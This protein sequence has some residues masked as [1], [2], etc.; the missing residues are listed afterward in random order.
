MDSPRLKLLLVHTVLWSHYKAAVFSSSHK[1]A[2]ARGI[3]FK[4]IQ[5][6]RNELK[7]RDFDSID[8][9]VHNYPYEL[10]FDDYLESIP[11]VRR[12]Q[13]VLRAINTY[14]PDVLVI[15]GYSDPVCWA[16]L[17][18]G[19]WKGI[20][21]ASTMGSTEKDRPRMAHKEWAKSV[22]LRFIDGVYCYGTPQRKYLQKLGVSEHKIITRRQATDNRSIREIFLKARNSDIPC[23]DFPERNFVFAGR[24]APEKNVF[25]LLDAF[26]KTRSDWGLII[27]GAGPEE[28][29]LRQYRDKHKIEGVFFVGSKRWNEV[30]DYFACSSVFVLPST[31]DP[32]GV[33][34][35]EAMLCELPVLVSTRCGCAPDLVDEGINGFTFDPW[36]MPSLISRMQEFIDGEHDLERMGKASLEIIKNFTPERAAEQLLD[37]AWKV[38]GQE[39]KAQ[40]VTEKI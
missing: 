1:L 34:V 26:R 27:V 18:F 13:R 2:P 32:W 37:G 5:I 10:L 23:D 40:P 29:A 7:R 25:F 11:L 22:L 15:P 9:N 38:S 36:Q 4:V 17:A 8:Y 24:L 21:I 28:E 33:V 20:R 6:A 39:F 3:D 12:I 19:K 31:R 16:A 30:F 14:S 35:N